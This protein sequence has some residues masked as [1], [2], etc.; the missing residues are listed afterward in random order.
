MHEFRTIGQR[1]RAILLAFGPS[2]LE[3]PLFWERAGVCEV[4][5]C[6]AADVVDGFVELFYLGGGKGVGVLLG[7]DFGVVEDFV[8]GEW[9]QNSTERCDIR[10][11]GRSDSPNPITNTTDIRLIQ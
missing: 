1:G 11:N 4:V 10:V 5:D 3:E 9:C 2:V 6:E 7:V 8:A